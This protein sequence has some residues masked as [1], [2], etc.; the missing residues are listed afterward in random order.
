MSE[1]IPLEELE[2]QRNRL[3]RAGKE[4]AEGIARECVSDLYEVHGP[5]NRDTIEAAVK[6]ACLAS[7]ELGIET[8]ADIATPQVANA[9][10]AAMDAC[11]EAAREKVAAMR[12]NALPVA[13]TS[14]AIN[15]V[16]RL[17]VDGNT[18]RK[19]GRWPARAEMPVEEATAMAAV[20]EAALGLD[21]AK[22]LASDLFETFA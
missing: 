6:R 16:I 13:T 14:L 4:T 10:L 1:G 17:L 7:Y 21:T 22:L 8:M 19:L 11:A 15:G 9:D 5:V 20:V 18:G 12:L 3:L 2:G